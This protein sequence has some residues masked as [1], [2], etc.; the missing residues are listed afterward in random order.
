MEEAVFRQVLAPSFRLF[1]RALFS[2]PVCTC[3]STVQFVV[4]LMSVAKPV[5]LLPFEAGVH[6]VRGFDRFEV[7]AGILA[8][9]ACFGRRR[10]RHDGQ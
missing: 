4:T 1:D 10:S 7:I 9:V 5:G 2:Y 8:K 3:S 6:D